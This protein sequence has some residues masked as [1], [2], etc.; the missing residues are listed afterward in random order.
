MNNYL[1]EE[2]ARGDALRACDKFCSHGS[3]LDRHEIDELL[4]ED[5]LAS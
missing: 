1:H 4:Q 5:M 3:A 2:V